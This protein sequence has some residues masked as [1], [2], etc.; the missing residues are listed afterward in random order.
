MKIGVFS[1]KS[2]DREY[3]ASSIVDESIQLTFV[4]AR[5]DESSIELARPF[6]AV[7]VFVNDVL[8]ASVLQH[9]HDYG[10][11]LIAL[12]CAG[13]NNVDL[14]AAKQL[15][16]SVCHVPEYS[17]EAVAEHTVGMMLTLSRKF[18]KAYNRVKEDNFSLKGLIGF[19]LHDKTV[20]IVGSGKIGSCVARLL[21]GFGCRVLVNDP[22]PDAALAGLDVVVTDLA[23]LLKESDIISLHC[24]LTPETHHLIDTES[25]DEMKDGVMLINTSR[26]AL[27]ETKAVIKALKSK[28]IGYL[29][30][31]VYEQESNLFFED[32]SDEVI[33][34]DVFQ[35]LLTFPNVIITAHQGFFTHEALQQIGAVT[36]GNIQNFRQG[37]TQQPEFLVQ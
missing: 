19:N 31:D 11:R 18:H 21:C 6:D 12:R 28:K 27:I 29:G 23:S 33:Q 32:L 20:G 37:N 30:L 16:L 2:Y 10:I 22:K 9:L 7:C 8:N 24:P 15:G 14:Q 5:L 4:E 1:S 26:G 3:L 13:F 35:R 34:D 25:I 17:P 36:F